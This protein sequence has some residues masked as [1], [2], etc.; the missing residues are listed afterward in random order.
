MR[1]GI[2]RKWRRKSRALHSNSD[3]CGRER[4]SETSAGPAD[5][6][7]GKQQAFG[8]KKLRPSWL[9]KRLLL[10][11]YVILELLSEKVVKGNIRAV[12]K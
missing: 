12:A 8:L 9:R 2:T 6:S 4:G 7:S 5:L 3:V 10:R 11:K 1:S